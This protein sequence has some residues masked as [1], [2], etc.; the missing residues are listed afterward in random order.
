MFSCQPTSLLFASGKAAKFSRTFCC[1][2][3][4]FV[5]L[6]KDFCVSSGSKSSFKSSS[7]FLVRIASYNSNN[8]YASNA[9]KKTAEACDCVR[10]P[11][12]ESEKV[13]TGHSFQLRVKDGPAHTGRVAVQCSAKMENFPLFAQC[14]TA[15]H[16]AAAAA[17]CVN[18]LLG[19]NCFHL[20]HCVMQMYRYTL[21]AVCG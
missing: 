2:F 1:R 11:C 5:F 18:T 10:R 6:W 13:K 16:S 20:L 17:L 8:T 4:S 3:S 21:R 9:E 12:K 19:N 14:C 15:L 7:E